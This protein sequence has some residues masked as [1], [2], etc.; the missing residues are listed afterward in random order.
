M[1]TVKYV[2]IFVEVDGGCYSILSEDVREIKEHKPRGSGDTHYVDILLPDDTK[3]RFFAHSIKKV[4][5]E[6]RE[7]EQDDNFPF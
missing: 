4:K 7:V 6:K 3:L 5:Y 1:R 2:P